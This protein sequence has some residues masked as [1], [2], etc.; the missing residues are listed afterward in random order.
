MTFP[1]VDG[2]SFPN[3]AHFKTPFPFSLTNIL[4][5]LMRFS[6]RLWKALYLNSETIKLVL[7][8]DPSLNRPEAPR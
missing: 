6:F 7:T 5:V 2:Y 8:A 4:T 1:H 3:K